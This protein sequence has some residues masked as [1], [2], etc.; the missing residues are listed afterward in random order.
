[1]KHSFDKINFLKFLKETK[2]K[3]FGEKKK[4]HKNI[5]NDRRSTHLFILIEN[6]RLILF[7]WQL[8]L[9]EI[10]EIREEKNRKWCL[11]NEILRI[12]PRDQRIF[13]H[14]FI[15]FCNSLKIDNKQYENDSNWSS[16]R[17]V[18]KF[19]RMKRFHLM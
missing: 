11:V 15:Q 13:L 9:I 1:M 5:V 7:A 19:S 6:I 3:F 17:S 12:V 18:K 2:G 10:F 16:N 4:I 8:F 14:I